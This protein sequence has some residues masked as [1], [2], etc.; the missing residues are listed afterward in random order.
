[1][2]DLVVSFS[3]AGR[4]RAGFA[5][6][7]C[8]GLVVSIASV[9]LSRMT[10]GSISALSELS[11]QKDRLAA[12]N[13]AV[14]QLQLQETQFR[15]TGEHAAQESMQAAIAPVAAALEE[16]RLHTADANDQQSL[17]DLQT[18]LNR[19]ATKAGSF[20]RLTRSADA[21]RVQLLAVGDRLS[22][23]A[24]ELVASP[25]ADAPA[26]QIYAVHL[27]DRKIQQMRVSSLQ[28]LA[29][30]DGER[31]RSFSVIAKSL[32]TVI[33]TARPLL[34]DN[35]S[36]LPPLL[37]EVAEYRTLFTSWAEATLET[38]RIFSGELLPESTAIQSGL[39][40]LNDAFSAS[41]ETVRDRAASNGADGTMF[42]LAM[43]AAALLVGMT[44]AGIT[45]RSIIPPL[46]AST[47]AMRRLAEGDHR[48]EITYTKRTDEIGAMAR[49]LE[50]FRTNA[51]RADELAQFERDA[52]SAQIHRTE[53][54]QALIAGFEGR[55]A[56]SMRGLTGA[57]TAMETTA[58]DLAATAEQTTSQ[59]MTV[60]SAA[61]QTSASVQ[62]VA[63]AA[64]QLTAS[65]REI[66]RQVNQSANVAQ[67]AAAGAAQTDATVKRLAEGAHKI[68]EVVQLISSI[69]AQTNLLALNA[70]I[71]A[72]RA[73]DAGKGFAVVAGEVKAL[74]SQTSR[75]TEEISQQINTIQNAT[76]DAVRAIGDI[77]GII[78]EINRIGTTVAAAV[79]QQGAA[80]AEIAR[81]VEQAAQGTQNVSASIGDVREAAGRTGR[82]AD[83]MHEVAA[84][85]SR[86]SGELTQ[87]IGRFTAEVKAA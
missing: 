34:G 39:R 63:S 31:I 11:Q 58:R 13:R 67:R 73:G 9:L 79:D 12:V 54:L 8:L 68:G 53:K 56:A 51:I 22:S 71:E 48:S 18:L 86:Q 38:D 87:E 55:V 14:D 62:T 26:D 25:D 41:F 36:L 61:D 10:G 28:F 4:I 57:S 64:E 1:V 33:Q 15:L 85:V 43:A 2:A 35:A 44:L 81:S 37:S 74:A 78:T 7:V 40:K 27:V 20:I 30:H 60:S 50:V 47:D 21:A 5:A 19:H 66:G 76:Q 69:A 49:M 32:E 46:R 42:E 59:S 83:R 16:A 45:V 75:A 23:S 84:D 65:I 80:T 6:L 77:A 29:A 17:G 70:T 52:Q 82:A 24:N 72:A 3:I